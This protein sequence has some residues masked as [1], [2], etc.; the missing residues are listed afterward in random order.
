MASIK[1]LKNNQNDNLTIDI[2]GSSSDDT[3]V[4]DVT[5]SSKNT[6]TKNNGNKKTVVNLNGMFEQPKGNHTSV[7][8]SSS[9]QKRVQ[10][11]RVQESKDVVIDATG[12]NSSSRVKADLSDLPDMTPEEAAYAKEHYVEDPM[13]KMLEG[14][15]SLL[16]KYLE[17]KEAELKAGYDTIAYNQ[18]KEEL[19]AEA[20]LTGDDSALIEFENNNGQFEQDNVAILD[21]DDILS[22]LDDN[23]EEEEEV[24]SIN[25]EEKM[26]PVEEENLDE[27]NELTN[28]ELEEV[29]FDDIEENENNEYVE[30]EDDILNNLD[31]VSTEE[32][33]EEKVVVKEEPKKIEKPDID[34]EIDQV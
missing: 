11:G 15:E 19:E 17:N 7:T 30:E 21:D 28:D 27:E 9:T 18:K 20:E 8:P 25:E 23:D 2:T 24:M 32:E 4:I 22:S 14:E 13:E 10:G 1:D 12:G 6:T 31:D 26:K 33:I 3:E 34:L 16:G 5:Q 29:D